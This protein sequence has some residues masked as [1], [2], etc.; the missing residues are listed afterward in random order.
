MA[1]MNLEVP[2][3]ILR[4]LKDLCTFTGEDPKA[5]IE[6][7]ITYISDLYLNSW[8]GSLGATADD[9]KKRYALA[10]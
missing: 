2:D 7:E 10:V 3:N 9:L 5:I 1:K 4:F 8:D 6:R